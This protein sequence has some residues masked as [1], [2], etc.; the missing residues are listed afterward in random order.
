MYYNIA[1]E[2]IKRRYIIRIFSLSI[3]ICFVFNVLAMCLL[4]Y[5]LSF[6]SKSFGDFKT[7]FFAVTNSSNDI[8]SS[9]IAQNGVAGNSINT[10]QTNDKDFLNVVFI[11]AGQNFKSFYKNINS[12]FK[13]YKNSYLKNLIVS[14]SV[15]YPLKIPFWEFIFFILLFKMLFNVL[16]RSVSVKGMLN[17]EP[18]CALS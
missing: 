10:A 7:D 17:R 13:K 18:A 3:S 5:D 9:M 16:P 2:I 12:Q 8:I 6:N 1:M 4:N 15:D 11:A 14:D